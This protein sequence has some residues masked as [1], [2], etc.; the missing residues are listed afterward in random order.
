MQ[1]YPLISIITVVLNKK[2]TIEETIKS[3]LSQSYKNI[4][5]VI[6][7][8]GSTDGTLKIIEKY[9]EKISEFISEKDKGVYDAMNKGIKLA[10]GDIVGLLNAD[11]FY[12]SNGVIEKI[13]RVFEEKNVECVWGDL[14]YVDAKNTDKV[15]RYWKSS[16]YQEGKFKKGWMPPHPAFFV[17]K[18]VYEKYGN[19]NLDFPIAADYEI[20]LRFLEGFRVKSCHI[21]QVLVKMRVGGQ[22]SKNLLNI[23]KANIECYRAWKINGLKVNFLRIFLKPLSKITQYFKKYGK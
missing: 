23:I 10:S 18:Q 3:V 9:K 15:I 4:E 14:V 22:S 2:D 16:E 21:P 17:R 7:D 12:A 20:M 5:Y 19:F 8:G 1:N 6:I 11:D 13:V